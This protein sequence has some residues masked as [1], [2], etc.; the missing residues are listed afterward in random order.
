MTARELDLTARELNLA[1]RGLEPTA[2][3]LELKKIGRQYGT[4]PAVH[5][6][7]DV[8]LA[9]DRGDWL[10]ITGPSGAGKSTLLNII[11]CLDQPTSGTYLI[12]GIDTTKLTDNAASRPAQPAHRVR[13]PVV[14]PAAL[15]VGAGKRDAGGGVSQPV[16]GAVGASARWRQSSGSGSLIA[17]IFRP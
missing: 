7:V 10:A 3:V 14:P 5:A 4:E 8:D 11:G 12:D 17:P 13:L 16:R 1:A 15:P 6:L 2:R 9:L